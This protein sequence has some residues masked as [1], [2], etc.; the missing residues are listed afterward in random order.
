MKECNDC[1]RMTYCSRACQRD[2]WLN[3]HNMTCCKSYTDEKVGQFQG[4]FIPEE[5][6]LDQRAAAKL[7]Y[8]E[9]NMTMIQLKVYLD[10][11]KKILSQ[12]KA[13]D[14]PLY[15]CIVKFD[16]C[17]SP[18]EV[19]VKKDTKK[20]FEESHSKENIRCVYH[21]NMYIRG[22]E[23][24]LAMQRFFSHEWLVEQVQSLRD[25]K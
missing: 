14:V 22:V 21:S 19:E 25:L 1:H 13:L 3:S 15:D 17:H 4:R 8:L 12:A 16:L 5:V 10:N 2:D 9:K 20:A 24:E 11:S 6:P 23:E 7:E 18:I